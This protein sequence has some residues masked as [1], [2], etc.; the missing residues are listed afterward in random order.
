[1]SLREAIGMLARLKMRLP[2]ACLS[3]TP[4]GGGRQRPDSNKYSLL[5]RSTMS[6]SA[7]RQHASIAA[8]IG[9]TTSLLSASVLATGQY[10]KD[11]RIDPVFG[12]PTPPV[13]WDGGGVGIY[14]PVASGIATWI[15]VA[16]FACA[17]IWGIVESRKTRSA[18][19]LCLSLSGITCV[20]AEIFLD[21]MGGVVYANSPDSIVFSLMGRHMGWFLISAWSAYGGLF[22]L[23]SYKVFSKPHLSNKFIWFGL[24]IVCAGQTVFE[25][26]LGLFNGI[27]YYYGNQPLTPFT[28]F[29]WW[30]MMATSG[31]VCLLSALVYRFN[32]SLQGWKAIAIIVMAPFTFCGFMGLISLPAWI[33]L[34]S[35]LPWLVTQVL[36]LMTIAAGLIAFAIV[37]KLVL[38]R[39]PLD[40]AGRGQSF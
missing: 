13:H 29:P 19:P 28:Q 4:V 18:I 36:G 11:I 1:M 32:A 3:G 34:N 30:M 17:L 38:Q 31:G 9:V 5:G 14:D 6:R 15:Y 26:T 33:A 8:A 25:E 10:E 35:E 7:S 39:E 40:L 24:A 37:M 12:L 22:A 2:C 27:Y 21:V 16:I 20:F 23:A